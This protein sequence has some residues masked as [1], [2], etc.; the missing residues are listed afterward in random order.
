M[1]CAMTQGNKID[2]SSDEPAESRNDV[3]PPEPGSPYEAEDIE[4]QENEEKSEGDDD[5]N[6]LAPPVNIGAG[7]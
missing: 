7:S 4:G 1:E 6:P 2:N 5:G 3:S